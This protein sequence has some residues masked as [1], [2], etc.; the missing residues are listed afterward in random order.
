MD[1]DKA[2]QSLNTSAFAF[3]QSVRDI[4]VESS[5]Q[6]S[7]TTS[8]EYTFDLQK[9]VGVTNDG[10]CTN[11]LVTPEV[12]VSA[13]LVHF[14]LLDLPA[15]NQGARR[16]CT[17]VNLLNR[18]RTFGWL[19]VSSFLQK[20]TIH[21]NDSVNGGGGSGAGFQMYCNIPSLAS[22]VLLASAGGGGGGG[23]LDL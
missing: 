7:M 2:V 12:S 17:D 5:C 15:H 10:S 22:D 18:T 19:P 20:K 14:L 8:L 23:K 1:R 11:L 16:D 21:S 13:D 9:D 4:I 3:V 6:P